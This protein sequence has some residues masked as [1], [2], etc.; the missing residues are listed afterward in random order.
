MLSRNKA[1][2]LVIAASVMLGCLAA[3][4]GHSTISR[5]DPQHKDNLTDK[6]RSQEGEGK[7]TLPPLPADSKK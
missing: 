4:C 3:G 7:V 2:Y 5:S 1:G 6:E